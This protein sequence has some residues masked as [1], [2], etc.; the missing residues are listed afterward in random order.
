M[1]GSWEGG[2]RWRWCGGNQLNYMWTHRHPAQPLSTCCI[3]HFDLVPIDPNPS[4][5][6]T[7]KKVALF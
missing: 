4:P 6:F 3:T 2:Q 1:I 7:D 5:V